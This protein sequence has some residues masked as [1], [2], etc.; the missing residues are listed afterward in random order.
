MIQTL[1]PPRE[2]KP[3]DRPT[4][5]RAAV[6]MADQ[7]PHRDRS[8]GITTMTQS[9]IAELFSRKDIDWTQIVSRSSF[10]GE[11]ES[12]ATCPLPFGTDYFLGRLLAD[13]LHPRLAGID[14]DVLYYPKGYAPWSSVSAP[15]IG[16]MHDTIIQ[17]YADHYPETRS[18][19]AFRYWIRAS[20]RSLERFDRVLTVSQTA[21]G[22]LHSFCDRHGIQ[23]PPIEVTYESSPWEKYRDLS[24]EKGDFVVHLAS[25]AVHK[26]TTYLVEQWDQLLRRR[27][28]L[29]ELVLV[30]SLDKASKAIVS[31]SDDMRV[32]PRL[33]LNELRDL[34]GRA[35][36]L[37]LPSE[38]EG[39]GLPAIEAYYVGT[40]ACYVSDTSVDEV[41]NLELAGDSVPG[42]FELDEPSSFETAL[43]EVLGL[44]SIEVAETSD[45]LYELF[46]ASRVGNRVVAALKRSAGR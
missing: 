37:I 21:A 29:P 15:S 20:R 45:R 12:V 6:Y 11:G 1:R 38:I 32:L 35:R 13:S 40:P 30:G 16:T 19:L 36:A 22:Q 2:T 24:F 41:L 44:S 31:Q 34:V 39:F 42:K 4:V 33:P 26:R 43:D 7:N 5:M 23:P 46:S 18:K 27:S 9:L 10:R 25:S 14:V 17:H 28:D 3:V 8:L